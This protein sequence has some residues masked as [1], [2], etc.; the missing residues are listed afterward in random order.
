MYN[1]VPPISDEE[2]D[3]VRLAIA[4]GVCSAIIIIIIIM[5]N[6]DNENI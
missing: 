3:Q 5:C 2:D 6:D 1:T 4:S